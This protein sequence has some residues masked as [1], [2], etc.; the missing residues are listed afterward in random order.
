M[1]DAQ[2][3]ILETLTPEQRKE[4]EKAF[5]K[6]AGPKRKLKKHRDGDRDG[7]GR[8]RRDDGEGRKDD[9]GGRRGWRRSR[10]SEDQD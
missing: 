3:K 1:D 4:L 5:D 9:E 8:R 10:S 7:K 6:P 2:K